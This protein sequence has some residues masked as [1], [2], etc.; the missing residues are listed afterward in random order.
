MLV[1]S[2]LISRSL[3]LFWDFLMNM[4]DGRTFI[5]CDVLSTLYTFTWQMKDKNM[6]RHDET[7]I[8][9]WIAL[10]KAAPHLYV[11]Q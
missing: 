7:Q 3:G 6:D 4:H 11:T 10:T 1:L 9:R 2:V 5:Y 8:N